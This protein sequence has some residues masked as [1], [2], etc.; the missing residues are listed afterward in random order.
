MRFLCICSSL[1]FFPDLSPT[2]LDYRSEFTRHGVPELV[3]VGAFPDRP[4]APRC[5]RSRDHEKAPKGDKGTTGTPPY[6]FPTYNRLKSTDAECGLEPGTR[7][8][9]ES[10]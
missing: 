9:E 3:R 10:V 2:V 1:G 6:Q 7:V 8:C 4:P 5:R